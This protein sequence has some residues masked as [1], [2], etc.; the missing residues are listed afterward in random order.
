MRKIIFLILLMLSSSI[1]AET[2]EWSDN[3]KSWAAVDGALLLS[4]WATTH[5]MT[6]R[7]N[8]GYYENN[9]ILGSHPTAAQLNLHFLVAV[10]LIYLVADQVPEYRKEI[11]EAVGAVELIAVANNLRIGLHFQF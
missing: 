11:L 6:H 10:P 8:E 3:E 9:P 1:M 2:R 5:N 4:D 7:Y